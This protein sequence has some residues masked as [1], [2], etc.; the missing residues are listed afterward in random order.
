[1]KIKYLVIISVFSVFYAC[2]ADAPQQK[3]QTPSSNLKEALPGVWESVSFEVNIQSANNADSTIVFK[4]AEENWEEKLG[5][6][7]IQTFFYTDNKYKRLFRGANTVAYDTLRG[8]WNVFGDTLMLIEP[9]ATYQYQVNIQDN[10][11]AE[12]RSLMDWDGDGES[13]DEYLGIERKIRKVAY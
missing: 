9:N 12:F 7:P 11:L 3:T 5:T 1:M 4:V 6:K 2:Q 8:M 13:D 10:G